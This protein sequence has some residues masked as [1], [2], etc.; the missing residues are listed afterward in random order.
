[1]KRKL[2]RKRIRDARDARDA[3]VTEQ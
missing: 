3:A 1:M 2:Q